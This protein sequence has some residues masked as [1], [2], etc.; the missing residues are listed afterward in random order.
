LS[1]GFLALSW[2]FLGFGTGCVVRQIEALV[3]EGATPNLGEGDVTGSEKTQESH[4]FTSQ[5]MP[6]NAKYEG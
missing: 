6:N 4:G 1:C 5:I 3:V 2:I